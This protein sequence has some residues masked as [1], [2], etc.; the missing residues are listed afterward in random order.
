MSG[1]IHSRNEW[2]FDNVRL[3]TSMIA[4]ANQLC[5][6][7]PE[8]GPTIHLIAKPNYSN[9]LLR[10]DNISKEEVF[11]INHSGVIFVNGSILVNGTTS[12]NESTEID[13]N[14]EMN[15]DSAIFF[16]SQKTLTGSQLTLITNNQSDGIYLGNPE[17]DTSW[18]I[19]RTDNGDL[20]FQ[21][22]IDGAWVSRHCIN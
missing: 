15:E 9:D 2:E 7:R 21:K 18:K 20:L 4:G 11:R 12:N 16:D 19:T 3:T 5:I 6:Q 17:E 1:Y 8:K 10:V 14:I 22:R 13:G